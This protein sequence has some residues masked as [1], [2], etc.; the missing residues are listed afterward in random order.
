VNDATGIDASKRD[1]HPS[2][3]QLSFPKGQGGEC[4]AIPE[5]SQQVL[6]IAELD[7]GQVHPCS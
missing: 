4:S 3:F 2:K 7:I 6:G 1:K 5:N